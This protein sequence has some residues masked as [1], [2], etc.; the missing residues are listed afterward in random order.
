[1]QNENKQ[2]NGS[3]PRNNQRS[4]GYQPKESMP[5]GGHQALAKDNYSDLAEQRILAIKEK[6]DSK[7]ELI[8]TTK[9]R[10]LLAMALDVYYALPKNNIGTKVELEDILDR[11]SYFKVRCYY[12]ASRE[13]A[14]RDFIDKTEISGYLEELGKLPNKDENKEETK[15]KLERQF[16]LFVRYL[17]AL[18]AF[19]AYY[20]EDKK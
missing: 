7:E 4:G 10:N 2:N 8:T 16:I 18:V 13:D 6:S 19:R 20:I 11:I 3:K 17:E 5:I 9:L 15:D 12:E 1:M 14:V